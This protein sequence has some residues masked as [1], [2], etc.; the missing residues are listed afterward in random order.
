M[1]A[2]MTNKIL[3]VKKPLIARGPRASMR[4]LV[5]V[6]VNLEVATRD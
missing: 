3:G 6:Q 2:L 5:T 1:F 4:P